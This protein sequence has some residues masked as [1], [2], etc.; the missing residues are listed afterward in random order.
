VRR[1]LRVVTWNMQARSASSQRLDALLDRWNPDLL[2]LQET[3]GDELRTDP[4]VHARFAHRFVQRGAG[5]YSGMA[6][7]CSEPFA[8]TGILD[9]PSGV[10]DRP[11]VLWARLGGEG[12]GLVV[13]NVHL[14]NPLGPLLPILPFDRAPR[15]RQRRALEGWAAA[16]MARGD[17]LLIGGDF[18]TIDC[19]IKGMTDVALSLGTARATWRPYGI[20]Y[21]PPLLRID[22]LFVGGAGLTPRSVATECRP[23]GTDHCA[24]VGSVVVES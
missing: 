6:I 22:H 7:F 1:E 12:T 24:L 18:N 9:A 20:P 5:T 23:T 3:N 10:W 15:D 19:R 13:A 21:A 17:R 2:L 16:R 8:E 14:R 4:A 11:R